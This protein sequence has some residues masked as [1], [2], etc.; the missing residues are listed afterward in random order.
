MCFNAFLGKIYAR[1]LRVLTIW[2]KA[3]SQERGLPLS[4]TYP[5]LDSCDIPEGCESFAIRKA[6]V[7]LHD[8]MLGTSARFG[9]PTVNCHFQLM[10]KASLHC[11]ARFA[12]RK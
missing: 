3:R 8:P 2:V 6:S 12:G 5:L 4:S 1:T 10:C 7:V 9:T 11:T